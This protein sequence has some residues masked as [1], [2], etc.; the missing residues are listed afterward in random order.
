MA[1]VGEIGREINK[2]RR[3]TASLYYRKIDPRKQQPGRPSTGK[4][5]NAPESCEVLAK[6]PGRIPSAP[7][8]TP[9]SDLEESRLLCRFHSDF[10]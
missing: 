8:Q 3:M 9:W 4:T 1:M 10:H 7:S 2:W 5:V 6:K